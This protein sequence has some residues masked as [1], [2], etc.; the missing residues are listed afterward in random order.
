MNP[1]FQDTF[2]PIDIYQLMLPSVPTLIIESLNAMGYADYMWLDILDKRRQ[3][4][5][6]Q[7]SEL[8]SD[9]DAVEL[10]LNKHLETADEVTLV[11]EGVGIPTAYGV[12]TYKP[13]KD[14]KF[15][16]RDYAFTKQPALWAYYEAWKWS[17]E[18]IVG[19]EVRETFTLEGTAHAIVASYKQSMKP[20]HT[21][22]NRYIREH[23][24]PFHPN[25]HIDNLCRLKGLD[26]GTGIGPVL[27]EKV[28]KEYGTFWQA[29]N[30]PKGNLID[31]LG[32]KTTEKLFDTIGRLR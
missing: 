21:T 28:I 18:H 2:E 10:Q 27:A 13:S 15:F 20:E 9:I 29:I 26:G 6:K 4:E 14:G 16:R 30:A 22:G 24:P 32:R 31:I 8:L 23:T 5:R 12:Q 7:L 19:V 1:L 17:M 11:V 3:W 25:I